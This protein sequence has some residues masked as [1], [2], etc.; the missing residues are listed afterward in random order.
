MGK[1][2]EIQVKAFKPNKIVTIAKFTALEDA[3][4]VRDQLTD[5]GF[6]VILHYPKSKTP[7]TD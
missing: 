1:H 2:Y 5:I 4:E 6:Q 3:Q 7:K